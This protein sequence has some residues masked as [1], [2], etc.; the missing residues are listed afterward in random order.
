MQNHLKTRIADKAAKI[1]IIGLGYVGLPLVRAFIKAGFKT[2]GYDLDRKKVDSLKAGK[3]YI[4]HIPSEWIKEYVES[5][6]FEP[7]VDIATRL[8]GWSTYRHPERT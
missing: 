3:S 4:A 2:I 7:T 1:G 5:G 8:D 6:A